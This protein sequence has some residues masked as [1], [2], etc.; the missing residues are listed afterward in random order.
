MAKLPAATGLTA[1]TF[2]Y[3]AT[4]LAWSAVANAVSYQ[5]QYAEHNTK[6]QWKNAPLVKAPTTY[7]TLTGLKSGMTY[8]FRVIANG[9]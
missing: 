4:T 1:T 7:T 5:V 8:D 3:A 9:V 6:L 2:T